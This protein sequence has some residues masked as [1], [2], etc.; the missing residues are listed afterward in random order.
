MTKKTEA[1]EYAKKVLHIVR[2]H[3]PWLS[4]LTDRL[5]LIATDH[6]DTAAISASGRLFF[7]PVWFHALKIDAAAFVMAHEIMHLAL[8]SH[9]RTRKE[10]Q[11]LFNIT[12]DFI[13]NEMLKEVF[14]IK[15]V[16]SFYVVP[17]DGLDWSHEYGS[18]YSIK[19]KSAEE[20]MRFIRDA[21]EQG[22]L[23]RSIFRKHWSA[24]PD[25]KETKQDTTN[26]PFAEKLKALASKG[27]VKGIKKTKIDI[28]ET[29]TDVLSDD[30]EKKLSPGVNQGELVKNKNI[31]YQE[32][33]KALSRKMIEEA[34]KEDYSQTRGYDAGA[35]SLVYDAIKALHKPPWE[36]AMQS[37]LE[38]TT[39]TGRTYARPSRR[40][41]YSD[42]VLPGASREG[43]TLHIV[44]DTSGS[45]NWVISIVLGAIASFC[46]ALLIPEIHIVQCDVQV[47]EDQ[48][49]TPDELK[50]FEIKGMGGSDMTDGMLKLANDEQVEKVIVITDGYIGY[51]EEDMPYDVLWVVTD[52]ENTEF[53][54]PYGQVVYMDTNQGHLDYL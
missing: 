36:V 47:S 24:N 26:R 23:N 37:W 13:I 5:E 3:L 1:L 2:I 38:H 22:K 48:W 44:L 20:L 27:T 42:F 21:L 34:I 35:H 14:E 18:H 52:T 53:K 43:H 12:H 45:M 7:N 17:A 16:C 28:I 9:E 50:S 30:L 19:G 54:P 10:D 25:E 33:S 4:S 49:Y 8:R 29:Q 11:Q 31:I 40:G 41:Q 15:N 46:E 39:R 51:P 6:I 32:I